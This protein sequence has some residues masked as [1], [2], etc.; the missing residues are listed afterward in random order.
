MSKNK[1]TKT[2]KSISSVKD[3]VEIK[4]NDPIRL[5]IEWHYIQQF[6]PQQTQGKSEEKNKNKKEYRRKTT[7]K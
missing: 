4:A 1:N 7:N 5:T 3:I 6:L 2:I